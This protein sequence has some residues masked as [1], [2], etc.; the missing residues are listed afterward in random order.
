MRKL[1]IVGRKTFDEMF[2][3]VD[4]SAIEVLKN[5]LKFSPN[6][7]AT[8]DQILNSKFYEPIRN[9]KLEEG[10]DPIEMNP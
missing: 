9:K 3:K 1:E 4:K 2:P 7:R 8:I 10:R 6:D 5:A